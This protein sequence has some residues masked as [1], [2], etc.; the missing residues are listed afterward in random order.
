[1][2]HVVIESDKTASR[3]KLMKGNCFWRVKKAQVEQY[4]ESKTMLRQ[5]IMGS[6]GWKVKL[7]LSI[8]LNSVII[9][10]M[11]PRK[12]TSLLQGTHVF[13]WV[14]CR[15]KV[16]IKNAQKMKRLVVLLYYRIWSLKILIAKAF[17]YQHRT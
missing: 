2:N 14:T 5:R 3:K 7:Y 4:Q 11:W 1:M 9:L 17:L 15:N 12:L 16:Y 10:V 8:N 6:N 13:N